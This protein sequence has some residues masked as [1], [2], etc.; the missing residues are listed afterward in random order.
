MS[1]LLVTT[2]GMFVMLAVFVSPVLSQEEICEDLQGLH[3][4]HGDD[5]FEFLSDA[6]E[7]CLNE[8]Q[9]L[10]PPAS[11]AADEMILS[12]SGRG[13]MAISVTLDLSLGTYS[14]DLIETASRRC[15]GHCM[16]SEVISV[17][18][19]CFPWSTMFEGPIISFPS[20]LPIEQDCLLYAT[21]DVNLKHKTNIDWEVSISKLS[22]AQPG[23]PNAQDWSAKGRG[24]K[25]LP[26]DMSFVPGI[27]RFNL[28]DASAGGDLT[29]GSF[30]LS[31]IVDMPNRCFTGST[32]FFEFPSQIRIGEECLIRIDFAHAHHRR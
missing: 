9:S 26:V 13:S 7:D 5:L 2:I 14:L 8:M 21:L 30:G 24:R 11:T 27:Y 32:V 6:G 16:A 31:G 19:S 22:D 10:S 28:G 1:R 20:R 17:P 3:A 15:L 12:E 4:E 25:F 29:G 23:T 18:E